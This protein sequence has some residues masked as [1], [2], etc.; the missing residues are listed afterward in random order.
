M[1][2]PSLAVERTQQILAAFERCVA[3]QGL[4]ATSLQDVADEAGMKRS[5]LRHYI[6]NRDALVVALAEH[7]ADRYRRQTD[8]LLASLPKDDAFEALLASLFPTTPR[9]EVGEIIVLESLIAAAAEDDAVREPILGYVD[10]LLAALR[11]LVRAAEPNAT[12]ARQDAVAYGVLSVWW[13]HSSLTPLRP[14]P[15]HRRAA[16]A[17]ARAVLRTEA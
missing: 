14:G 3:R 8:D 12:R 16:L 11:R 15:A 7:V 5:I 1:G 6:G 4:A 17:A 9:E 10:F 13:N 2:R